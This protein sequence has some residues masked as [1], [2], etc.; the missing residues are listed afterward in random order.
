MG[1][2]LDDLVTISREFG[3]DP[4]WV[5]AGGGNTSLKEGE[6]LYIKASGH[7]LA[8][9]EAG[10]FARM[11]RSKLT[12][13]WETT[14]PSGEDARSVAERERLVLAD[15]MASRVPGEEKRPSVET[16][17]HDL[18]PW[19]LIVHLHPTLVNGLTCGARG[20]RISEELFGE[21]AVWIPVSDPGYVL[22]RVIRDDLAERLERSLDHPD[23]I[24]LAN[25]GVFVGG[26]DADEVR[27][28]YARLDRILEGQLSR[29][30]GA[31]PSETAIP[32]DKAALKLVAA[33]MF[34]DE[35]SIRY[36]RGGELDS[37]LE[38]AEA[39]AALTGSLTP[40][41]IVYAGPGA[42]YIGQEVLRDSGEAGLP[43]A[44]QAGAAAYVEANGKPPNV[45]L[46]N[47][48]KEIRGAFVAAAG[49]KALANAVLLLENALEIAAYAESFGG[50]ICL[51]ER[52]VT[53]ILNWEVENYRS[54]VS[55]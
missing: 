25:H 26:A 40:D 32:G 35:S 22:A 48:G 18:L 24:F 23:F 36:L 17:L 39:A 38:S 7:P 21:K 30:P 52:F 33:G 31:M 46:V 47:D 55:S 28:K 9:I 37:Y 4:K 51:E 5:V 12:A 11:D 6:V 44:W 54:K 19:P 29:R 10:G 42:M 1:L 2:N 13:I 34:G 16:M 14:Y 41:H 3:T 45:V 49:D 53:F 50:P 20:P 8:A 43:K 27:E 15:M